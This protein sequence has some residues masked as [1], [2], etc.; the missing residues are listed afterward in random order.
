[1]RG[2]ENDVISA[3]SGAYVN[4]QIDWALAGPGTALFGFFDA[5]KLGGETAYAKTGLASVGAGVTWPLW[6]GASVTGT[7]GVPLV[8]HLGE[9]MHVNKARFD[10]ALVATW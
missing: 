9:E 1:M 2:Y 6:Q 8:R 4:A 7:V 3:E 5:G 10:L